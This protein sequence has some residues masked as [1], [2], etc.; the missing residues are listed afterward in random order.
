METVSHEFSPKLIRQ[1][2][3]LL[4]ITSVLVYAKP[5]V[6]SSPGREYQIKV[7]NINQVEMYVSNYGKICRQSGLLSACYW[8]KG[9]DHGYVF[10]AGLS[11][12]E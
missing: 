6:Y 8:P 4:F 10:A 11:T 1:L 2:T 9:S 7:H 12:A 5:A 3:I